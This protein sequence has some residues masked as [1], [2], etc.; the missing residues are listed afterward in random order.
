VHVA[1][2]PL[3][4]DA[5]VSAAVSQTAALDEQQQAAARLTDG[6]I[7][8]RAAV[9]PAVARL[10]FQASRSSSPAF[11]WRRAN[12]LRLRLTCNERGNLHLADVALSIWATSER[13]IPLAAKRSP[14]RAHFIP[15]Q[16]GCVAAQSV[17]FGSTVNHGRCLPAVARPASVRGAA[18]RSLD[19]A[20]RSSAKRRD[21][22]NPSPGHRRAASAYACCAHS[23]ARSQSWV[24][25][26]N[27]ARIRPPR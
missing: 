25:R 20:Q 18:G 14:V 12:R 6:S 7:R 17:A 8:D 15:R 19:C 21:D 23:S 9:S 10:L 27:A 26:I 16:E 1:A 2:A 11:C 13:T 5:S 24:R 22:G 4:T 3:L